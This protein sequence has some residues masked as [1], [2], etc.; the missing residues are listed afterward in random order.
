MCVVVLLATRLILGAVRL[1]IRLKGI[2]A[3]ADRILRAT[4]VAVGHIL[5]TT[6][7][8]LAYLLVIT[9]AGRFPVPGLVLH[10]IAGL[11]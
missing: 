5:R 4:V 11:L 7:A 3:A 9:G 8:D 1:V 10:P 2:G 6:G